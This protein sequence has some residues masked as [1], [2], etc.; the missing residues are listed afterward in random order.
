[1]G[2]ATRDPPRPY[3]RPRRKGR[4]TVH[5]DTASASTP[6]PGSLAELIDRQ[7]A[8]H[9]DKPFLTWY[10]DD[11]GERVEL[12]YR[13]FENWTAKVANLLVEELGAAP[14]DRVATV[15][16]SHWRAAAIAFACWRAGACLVPVDLAAPAGTVAARLRA[17][18]CV[19]AFV[20][21]RRLDDLAAS[22]GP[23]PGRPTLVAVGAGLLARPG[24]GAAGAAL[25]FSRVVPGMGDA[26][27]GGATSLADDALLPGDRPPGS[28]LT[29]GALLV[30]AAEAAS[31]LGMGARD[32]LFDG[33]PASTALGVAAGLVA[34]FL[35]GAGVVVEQ[36][37]GPGG[38]WK[39]LA[40]ERVAVALLAAWQ[41]E[42]LLGEG[43][44]LAG[45][46]L[47]RLRSV[48]CELDRVPRPLALAWER[49]FAV[50][51]SPVPAGAPVAAGT[52]RG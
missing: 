1:M 9:G 18:G 8:R 4:S 28:P 25:D 48:A 41:V 44:D 43:A 7:M 17:A 39:R 20:A 16:G 45:L 21:E 14:G 13:T 27:D 22:L 24:A 19:A 30:A 34:P 40:D 12:S 15:L 42:A 23:R 5:P 38:L 10:D 36:A 26:F 52:E 29:Q 2:D 31:G 49:R 37:F 46:D 6:R 33:L 35:V 11:L 3:D 32:R 47:G 51:L 50:P